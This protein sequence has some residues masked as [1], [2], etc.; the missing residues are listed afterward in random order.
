ME[1]KLS[2]KHRIDLELTEVEADYITLALDIQSDDLASC[3]NANK[4]LIQAFQLIN[5]RLAMLSGRKEELDFR[6]SAKKAEY[7]SQLYWAKHGWDDQ[8]EKIKENKEARKKWQMEGSHGPFEAPHDIS[9]FMDVTHITPTDPRKL[10]DQSVKAIAETA[11]TRDLAEEYAQVTKYQEILRQLKDS[12]IRI[13]DRVSNTVMSFGTENK[14]M[15]G[16]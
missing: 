15:R 16:E 6:L 5:V 11:A 1:L 7:Q 8:L 12:I 3:R 4:I 10:T 9:T 14:I 2:A 13:A